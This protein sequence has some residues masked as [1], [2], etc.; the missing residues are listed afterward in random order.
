VLC[1]CNCYTP[2]WG[3]R[4]WCR[5][6]LRILARLYFFGR[7]RLSVTVAGGL[8]QLDGKDLRVGRVGNTLVLVR[9]VSS[10]GLSLEDKITH[11][12]PGGDKSVS[13]SP[14][15]ND[16]ATIRLMDEFKLSKLWK[17]RYI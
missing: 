8:H 3:H 17:G 4:G 12:I 16:P 5:G 15:I 11:M 7:N 13:V 2:S 14:L 9:G 1:L 10:L 6:Y